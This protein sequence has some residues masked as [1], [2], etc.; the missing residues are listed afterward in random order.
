[1]VAL[2]R[3]RRNA[4]FRQSYQLIDFAFGS[5]VASIAFSS[6]PKWGSNEYHPNDTILAFLCRGNANS[7]AVAGSTVI[8]ARDDSYMAAQIVSRRWGAPLAADTVGAGGSAQGVKLLV[9][10][11]IRDHLTCLAGFEYYYNGTIYYGTDPRGPLTNTSISTAPSSP[12][13]QGGLDIIGRTQR[14]TNTGSVGIMRPR[15]FVGIPDPISTVQQVQVMMGKM[16]GQVFS[17]V[18]LGVGAGG[19]GADSLSFGMSI[20]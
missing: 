13:F 11:G 1:M 9:I 12:M 10:R 14:G 3:P 8:A 17:D 5:G 4:E 16:P 19:I 15:S 18:D 20:R 2:L 7:A 6:F